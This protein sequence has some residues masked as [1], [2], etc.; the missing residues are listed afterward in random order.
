MKMKRIYYKCEKFGKK[1][2]KSSIGPSCKDSVK[3]WSISL[4]SFFYAYFSIIMFAS[5]I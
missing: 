3:I 1:G 2:T 5:Y 4:L